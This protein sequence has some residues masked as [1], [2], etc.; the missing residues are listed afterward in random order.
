[1]NQECKWVELKGMESKEKR[2]KINTSGL[3]RVI[4]EPTLVCTHLGDLR[5][6]TKLQNLITFLVERKGP[7]DP[8]EVSTLKI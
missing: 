5:S 4:E 1:M 2:T 8:L 6:L 7:R 3:A